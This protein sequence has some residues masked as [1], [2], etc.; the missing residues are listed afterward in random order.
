MRAAGC[1]RWCVFF[2]LNF[3]VAPLSTVAAFSAKTDSSSCQFSVFFRAAWVM[4]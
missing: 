4:E 1:A 3:D 2:Y